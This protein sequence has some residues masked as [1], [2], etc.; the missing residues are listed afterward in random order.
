MEAAS[1][2][3][4]AIRRVGLEIKRPLGFS[5]TAYEGFKTF[6]RVDGTASVGNCV[7]CHVP[8]NFSDGR[9]HNAGISEIEY[10]GA[11]GKGSFAKLAIPGPEAKRPVASLLA[12][13]M[14]GDA[15]RADLGYWNW[16]DLAKTPE[17]AGERE[18][19]RSVEAHGR[20]FPHS[21]PAQPASH[22]SLHAQRCLRHDRGRRA[23]QD[24]G[25]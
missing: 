15:K 7:A 3:A 10:E 2:A 18:R 23:R 8:P 6:F 20:R 21:Q 14:K 11:N 19:C 17:R 9:F 25:E 16:I 24:R 1:T 4:S 13:P 22:R 5:A 12:V